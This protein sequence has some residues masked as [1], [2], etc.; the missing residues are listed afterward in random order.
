MEY[1]DLKYKIDDKMEQLAESIEKFCVIKNTEYKQSYK[2][3]LWEIHKLL[4]IILGR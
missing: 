3:D 1:E 2:D 4:S